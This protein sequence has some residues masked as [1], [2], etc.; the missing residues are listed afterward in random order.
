MSAD[1]QCR[2]RRP[3]RIAV[4]LIVREDREH[5][6]WNVEQV[7]V[8]RYSPSNMVIEVHVVYARTVHIERVVRPLL[9]IGAQLHSCVL[10]LSVALSH[11]LLQALC[12]ATLLR[13]S[14]IATH[15]TVDISSLMSLTL[16]PL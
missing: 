16:S 1:Q 7:D 6:C 10:D 4:V 11:A 2:C 5:G 13:S 3:R 8:P 15:R 14:L 12:L 9:I